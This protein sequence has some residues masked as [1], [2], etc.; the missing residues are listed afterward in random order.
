M[1]DLTGELPT[2][3]AVISRTRVVSRHT[4]RTVHTLACLAALAVTLTL[5]YRRRHPTR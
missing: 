3:P 4:E 5:A 2:E 1:T